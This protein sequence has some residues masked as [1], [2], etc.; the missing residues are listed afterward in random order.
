MEWYITDG[1]SQS[2]LTFEI[3][4]LIVLVCT[5]LF[6]AVSGR[7]IS[8]FIG[9]AVGWI[10]LLSL[11]VVAGRT[12]HQMKVPAINTF[13]ERNVVSF[14]NKQIISR[15][16]SG[17]G[18]ISAFHDFTQGRFDYPIFVKALQRP[19]QLLLR[20]NSGQMTLVNFQDWDKGWQEHP[21]SNLPFYFG[22][23]FLLSFSNTLEDNK[24]LQT[25][26]L[27]RI[28]VNGVASSKGNAWEID[29]AKASLKRV[30]TRKSKNTL[31]HWG[32]QFDGKVFIPGTWTARVPKSD[33]LKFSNTS[34]SHCQEENTRLDSIEVFSLSDGTHLK[35][36]DILPLLADVS[37]PS[38]KQFLKHCE[39]PFHLNDIVI[40]KTEKHAGFFPEGK[41]GDILISMAGI[42]TIALL[43]RDDH[44][45]KWH[46]SKFSSQ[47]SPRLSDYGT[48]FV[49]DNIAS[50]EIHGQSRITEVDIQSNQIVGMWEGSEGN[51]FHS[52]FMGRIQ[53]FKDRIFVVESGNGLMFEL[54]CDSRPISLG[55]KKQDLI[56]IPS[57]EPF[58][59][60]AL[61]E[62]EK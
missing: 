11:L 27:S 60:E 4:L 6:I 8:S 59:M 1:D 54:I 52:Q 58:V 10:L 9:K 41:V 39:D 32:D 35:S 37:D 5:G 15:F 50:N 36:I 23:D 44:R 33:L 55:C 22:D 29:A 21:D 45:V 24:P 3:V 62:P 61:I 30:W 7:R 56:Q 25:I 46:C 12:L 18:P 48:M 19:A 51:N 2:G 26:S 49:F 40:V 47:H 28:V 42:N 57:N 31:H 14:V 38:F 17:V 20:G 34:F 53:L 16:N 13:L 43:D